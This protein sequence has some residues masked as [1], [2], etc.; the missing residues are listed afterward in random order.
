METSQPGGAYHEGRDADI[1]IPLPPV[2]Q[3]RHGDPVCLCAGGLQRGGG[4]R[5]RQVR[6]EGGVRRDGVPHLCPLRHLRGD[7]RGPLSAGAGA[8]RRHGPGLRK[9]QAVLLLHRPGGHGGEEPAGPGGACGKGAP[10]AGGRG[11]GLR[12]QRHHV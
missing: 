6:P 2:R 9:D 7:P 10:A 11:R 3:D 5:L 12:G 1:R 8:P 4:V